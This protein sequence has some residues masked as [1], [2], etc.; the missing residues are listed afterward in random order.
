M[1]VASFALLTTLDLRW[2]RDVAESYELSV[3]DWARSWDKAN[4]RT[5]TGDDDPYGYRWRSDRPLAK[6]QPED[7]DAGLT[8]KA[9]SHGAGL[10]E[11][12]VLFS[13]QPS[14]QCLLAFSPA[15]IESHLTESIWRPTPRT[16]N[17]LWNGTSS[18]V[19]FTFTR[20]RV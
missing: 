17:E 10:L 14:L 3:H 7:G 11:T 9:R 13:T 6:T 4:A 12:L 1:I 2:R 8:T 16:M 19:P 18:I 20:P 15:A 5:G